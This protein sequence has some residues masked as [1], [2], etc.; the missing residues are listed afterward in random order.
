MEI[1]LYL[2]QGTACN[3]YLVRD[4][5]T[6]EAFMVDAGSYDHD[7]FV[8]VK[9]K[10]LNVKYLILTHGHGD[11]IG[12][13]EEYR[14]AF[15][16]MKVVSS[17]KEKE[18]LEEPSLNYSREIWGRPIAV[19]PD[20]TVKDYDILKVAEL[21]LLIL[22]TP[23]HTE[24][25]ISILCEDALFSGDTLFKHGVGRTDLHGGSMSEL[26][27]SIKEKLFT[28]PDETQVFPGHMG[29]TTIGYEKEN[30]PFV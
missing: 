13:V 21:E 22:E 28:L 1:R 11:H 16:D 20:I 30:N 17:L 29:V 9:E 2:G 15:P 23:G 5:K 19:T 27:K 18:T 6:K 8:F 12:G 14:K 24:G 7:L 3:T 4:E 26:L 10:N 25:G